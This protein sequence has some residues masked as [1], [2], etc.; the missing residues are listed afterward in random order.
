MVPNQK[1]PIIT[2]TLSERERIDYQNKIQSAKGSIKQVFDA[3]RLD[4]DTL[5]LLTR[6][7]VDTQEGSL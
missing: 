1:C 4:D 7:D 5:I 3:Y 6:S 2:I